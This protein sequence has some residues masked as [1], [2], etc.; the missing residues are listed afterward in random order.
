MSVGARVATSDGAK[1]LA[2]SRLTIGSDDVSL[3]SV[4]GDEFK[5]LLRSGSSTSVGA[6]QSVDNRTADYSPAQRPLDVLDLCRLGTTTEAAIE[7]MRQTTYTPVA[8]ETA[9]ATSTTTGT[10]PEATLAFEKVTS[11]VEEIPSWVPVTARAL[12]DVDE[13]RGIIDEQLMGD[14]R[15]RL[16]AQVLAGNGTSPN[17]RGLDNTTGVG[18]QAKGGDSVP[19]ALAKGIALVINAGWKPTAVVLNPD[20]WTDALAITIPAGG[21]LSEQLEL[22]V[23]KTAAAAA[24][25]AYVG[26][27]QQLAVWTRAAEIFASRSHASY[28]TSNLVAILASLQVAVGVLAPAAFARVTGL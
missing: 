27:W 14:A 4:S 16:E 10:K 22:P 9:E 19:L 5:T 11:P 18:A 23:V 7:Y 26:D 13:L 2:T 1:Q 8:V 12:A 15:R 25:T 21:S 6:F 24:G 28:F 17:L 3:A 20:D